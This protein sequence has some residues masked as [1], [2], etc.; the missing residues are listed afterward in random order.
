MDAP[1]ARGRQVAASDTNRSASRFGLRLALVAAAGSL[2]AYMPYRYGVRPPVF[3]GV[4]GTTYA[5]LFPVVGLV[6]LGAVLMAWRPR[7]L[8]ALERPRWVML[9]WVLGLCSGV[10]MSLGLVHLPWLLALVPASP[11]SAGLSIGLMAIHHVF[12]GL[13]ALAVALFP[14]RCAG[15]LRPE[16]ARH[17]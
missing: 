8:G 13:A 1:E 4:F 15:V 17:T 5:A 14:A 7:L 3:E 2:L 10:W 11:L 12:L 16:S 9:R 6:A